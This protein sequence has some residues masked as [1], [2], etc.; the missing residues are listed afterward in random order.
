MSTPL[1]FHAS[2]RSICREIL[3]ADLSAPD[4][5]PIAVDIERLQEAVKEAYLAGQRA[6]L[7]RDSGVDTELLFWQLMDSLP[8]NVYFK[9]LRSRFICVN[10]AQARFLGIDDPNEAIG[11]SDFDFF[12]EVD[13]RERFEGEQDIIRTGRGWSLQEERE[14]QTEGGKAVLVA[15]K[16]PLRDPSGHIVGTF[17][18]SRDVTSRYLA[19][20]EVERQRNL[21]DAVLQI[22]PCRVFARS[23]DERFIVVN[24]AYRAALGAESR[25]SLVG[26][27][28][29]EF[30]Q[31]EAIERINRQDA[32][33]RATGEPIRDQ[34]EYDESAGREG[35]WIVTSKV[36]LYGPDGSIDGVV[37]MT[38][39]IT[40]QKQ[41]EEE[42]RVLGAELRRK[43]SQYEAELLMARQLQEKL[44]SIGFDDQRHLRQRGSA[45]TL[46]AGYLYR[47]SNHLAGDFFD[48]IPISPQCLG[49]L[50]CDVMG[51]GVKAALVTML[52][53]GLML[54][55]PSLLDRPG[56][57]LTRLNNS[58]V[59]LAEDKE[60]PRF[61]TAV[62]A[63]IDLSDGRVRIANAGH[64]EPV[65]KLAREG[66]PARFE[67]C[68]QPT[69]GPALGL[70]PG[71]IY[72]QAEFELAGGAELLFFT[73][74][75]TEQRDAMG[76]EFGLANL[77]SV[78]QQTA[79]DSLD[80]Q[81]ASVK[82]ALR[83]TAG[84]GAF[85]DDICLVAIRVD[86]NSEL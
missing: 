6:K 56:A 73:D 67:R 31:G 61:V 25:E 8:D 81:L 28:L 59:D 69:I 78:L 48:I 2:A 42:A 29:P 49:I 51:H 85:D 1:D 34:I 40:E 22:L 27:S 3:R 19:E 14:I 11:K 53:R 84:T 77:E 30:Y 83:L 4:G 39:D 82:S 23:A 62:Y 86:K 63:T 79:S 80:A 50:V 37:G 64:P 44:M 5:A 70:I 35:R 20:R 71:E 74:G 13:A 12:D 21:L 58:L 41:A 55:M 26:R 15:S 9:D 18:V 46:Q 33:I 16:L 66:E 54:E 60:F 43:N 45:W 76:N 72:D 68:P 36:P 47:P 65:W 57:V 7:L 38:L 52:L 17:G 75:I 10:L 32:H 24:E